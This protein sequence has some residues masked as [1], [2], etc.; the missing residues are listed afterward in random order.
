M[1]LRIGDEELL[2]CVQRGLYVIGGVVPMAVL[3]RGPDGFGMQ[4][5]VMLDVMAPT[6]ADSEA[7]L[8]AIRKTMRVRNIY[9]GRILS[10]SYEDHAVSIDFHKLPRI[11][12]DAIVLPE[13]LLER[14]ERHT[15]RFGRLAEKLRSASRHLKRGLL[16]HGSPGTGKTLTAMY[17]AG[18]S[19]DRTVILLTGRSLGLIVQSCAIARALQPATVIIEDVDLVGEERTHQNQ[20]CN[21]VL[22]ELLNQMDGLADDADILFVLTTNR[23]DILEP[24]LAARPGRI[25]QAIEVPLPDAECRQAAL[26]PVRPGPDGRALRCRVVRPSHRGSERGL[27]PRASAP[28]RADRGRRERSDRH[29]RPPPR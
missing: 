5:S 28:R 29:Q 4:R 27:H 23:P 22:F 12:R 26:R 21:T 15:I 10:L 8:A 1:N 2:A 16:L 24:A 9:R 19:P 20:A 13:G 7:F 14:V 11:E 6:K 18:Q 17:I 3:L 25:D